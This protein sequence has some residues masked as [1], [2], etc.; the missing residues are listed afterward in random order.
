VLIAARVDLWQPYEPDLVETAREMSEAHEWVIPVLNGR[1]YYNKPPLYYWAAILTSRVAGRFTELTARLPSL[2]AAALSLVLVFGFARRLFGT[3]TAGLA[4]AMFVTMPVVFST[5]IKGMTDALLGATTLAATVLF[6]A[7]L[8]DPRAQDGS[9]FPKLLLA[10]VALGLGVLA[11]G[12]VAVVFVALMVGPELVLSGAWRRW[13]QVLAWEIAGA[14]VFLAIAAPWYVLGTL[15][16]G[17]AF[18]RG[19]LVEPNVG[20][21]LVVES[22]GGP[23]YYLV[24]LPSQIGLWVVLVPAT[25][26]LGASSIARDRTGF[27]PV[28]FLALGTVLQILFLSASTAKIAK[29][30]LPCMPALALL[31]GEA[32]RRLIPDASRSGRFLLRAPLALGAVVVVAGTASLPLL[33]DRLPPLGLVCLVTPA[34]LGLAGGAIAGLLAW[35]HRWQLAV[36]ALASTLAAASLALTASPCLDAIN[37]LKTSRPFTE[38]AAK[39]LQADVPL[40]GFAVSDCESI[41][42]YYGRTPYRLVSRIEDVLEARREHGR[43][44]VLTR[45]ALFSLLPAEEAARFRVLEREE[46]AKRDYLLVEGRP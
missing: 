29:Y 8:L 38:R 26:W 18:L 19:A 45:E 15:R 39:H 27:Q 31:A 34:G 23:F 11:K 35:R 36:P 41:F 20:R 42:L 14:V 32:V 3:R 46:P 6:W 13:R 10:H 5:A 1:P 21:F 28:R 12:P 40:L 7:A 44:L 2:L 4:I 33:Q 43:I 17:Q 9:R 25:A 30:L 22:K 16:H 37:G 24:N